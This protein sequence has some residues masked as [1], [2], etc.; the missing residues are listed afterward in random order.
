MGEETFLRNLGQFR[1]VATFLF[2]ASA[3]GY[4]DSGKKITA[5]HRC[6]ARC[7][8]RIQSGAMGCYFVRYSFWYSNQNKKQIFIIIINKI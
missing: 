5:Y 2:R 7:S 6:E 3:A 1:P 4:L 8:D